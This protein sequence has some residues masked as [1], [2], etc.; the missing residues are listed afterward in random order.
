ME[1]QRRQKTYESIGKVRDRMRNWMTHAIGIP[2]KRVQSRSNSSRSKTF[3]IFGK[4]MV[5]TFQKSMK[6]LKLCS[7][8]SEKQK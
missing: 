2:E 8:T 7:N 1:R 6:Y 3:A 4:K 5:E